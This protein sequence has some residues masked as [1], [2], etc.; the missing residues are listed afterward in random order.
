MKRPDVQEL[1][2]H[3][4]IWTDV[5]GFPDYQISSFGNVKSLK[6]EEEKSLKPCKSV[7]KDGKKQ[8][9]IQ[10]QVGLWRNRKRHVRT[11][12]RLVL[13]HFNPVKN[14]KHLHADHINHDTSDNRLS[15]LRW[16]SA[17]DNKRHLQIK[18]CVYF[19]KRTKKWA[20][21]INLNCKH[22][23]VGIY[24]TREE[25]EKVRQQAVE[26]HYQV[27]AVTDC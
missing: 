27:N 22:K 1:C 17:D 7:H 15:N 9:Y 11:I 4:E 19:H 12:S 21:Q 3:R 6:K 26:Q 18:G 16:L 24:S 5:K 14:M 20:V 23:H 2:E 25:A 10:Y 13:M 8:E